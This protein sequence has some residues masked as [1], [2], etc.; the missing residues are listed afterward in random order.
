MKV[1]NQTNKIQ[2]NAFKLDLAYEEWLRE[3]M[4]A[5]NENELNQM[6]SNLKIPLNNSHFEPLK[7]A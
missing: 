3:F 5:P 6:E 1:K 7:G 2:E 4:N